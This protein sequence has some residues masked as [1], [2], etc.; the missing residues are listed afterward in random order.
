MLEGVVGEL[1]AVVCGSVAVITGPVEC[2]RAVTC[3]TEI[4][5]SEHT[6]SQHVQRGFRGICQRSHTTA[7]TLGPTLVIF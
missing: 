6:E 2:D 1:R 7:L 5:S 3:N 4:K